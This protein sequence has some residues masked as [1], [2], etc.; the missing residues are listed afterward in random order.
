MKQNSVARFV[1]A[2]FLSLLGISYLVFLG[3]SIYEAIVFPPSPQKVTL[4]QAIVMDSENKPA[5]LFFRKALYISIT[6]A[7]WECASVTQEDAPPNTVEH[8]HGVLLNANKDAYVFVEI[9]GLYTCQDLQN[10]Q[11]TGKLQRMTERPVEY[12]SDAHGLVIIDEDSEA[13]TFEL[14]THCT[15]AEAR[16]FP[17]FFFIVPFAMG[18]IFAYGKCQQLNQQ[19][20]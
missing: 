8:T 2:I 4:A 3:G 7:I 18:G 20:P 5:F 10:M 12:Q 16:I 15:P 17:L 11:V 1:F 13:I 14:C 6:D 9:N 19:Q